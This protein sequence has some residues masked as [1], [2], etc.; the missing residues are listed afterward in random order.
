M[1]FKEIQNLVYEEYVTNGYADFWRKTDSPLT[2][3]IADIAE[4]GFITT[5]IAEGIEEMFKSYD[6]QN[7]NSDELGLECADVV[8]RVM[9]FCSRLGIDLERMIIIKHEKNMLRGYLHGKPKE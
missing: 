2:Q 8:I 9:N 1:S 6:Y 3:K 4:F 5:E 7:G